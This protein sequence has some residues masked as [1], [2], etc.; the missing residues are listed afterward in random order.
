[1]EKLHFIPFSLPELGNEEVEEVIDTLKSGWIT[2]GP[3]VKRFESD[4][5]EFIGNSVHTVAV[6]SATAGLHL[7]LEALGVSKGDEVIVP[8]NLSC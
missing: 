7:A 3:K 8:S 2:S 4:F 1:M 6:N 5:Q